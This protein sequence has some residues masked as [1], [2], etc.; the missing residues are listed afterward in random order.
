MAVAACITMPADPGDAEGA[1]GEAG[2][3]SSSSGDPADGALDTST[4]DVATPEG[5]A[6]DAPVSDGATSDGA[7]SDPD[8][9]AAEAGSS[10]SGSVDPDPVGPLGP[11]YGVWN[12]KY[13]LPPSGVCSIHG[14]CGRIVQGLK[15]AWIVS[16]TGSSPAPQDAWVAGATMATGGD[17]IVH[18]VDGQPRG[19]T[20]LPKTHIGPISGSGPNDVWIGKLH[21]DGA[22]ISVNPKPP[23]GTAPAFVS[24]TDAW[25]VGTSTWHWDGA[26]WTEYAAGT[27]KTL[28]AVIAFGPNDAWAV[29][30]TA[31]RHWNGVAWSDPP[32]PLPPGAVGDV[33]GGTSSSDLWVGG[34]AYVYRFNG[35][36]WTTFT[37]DGNVVAIGGTTTTTRV[38]TTT[39]LYA[40]KGATLAYDPSFS[41]SDIACTRCGKCNGASV[42]SAN[43]DAL[44]VTSFGAVPGSGL[45]DSPIGT[46]EP[47]RTIGFVTTGDE[48]SSGPEQFVE[49]PSQTFALRDGKPTWF[50]GLWGLTNVDKAV[51]LA[52]RAANDLWVAGQSESAGVASHWDG[53][54][55]MAYALPYAATSTV[56]AANPAM[57]WVLTKSGSSAPGAAHF[58]GAKWTGVPGPGS[59]HAL[60]IWGSSPTDAVAV[61]DDGCKRWNGATWSSTPC[62][63]GKARAVTGTGPADIWVYG[64]TGAVGHWNGVGWF[65]H[66]SGAPSSTFSAFSI[67]AWNDVWATDYSK[68]T[69]TNN[70]RHW[71]GSKWEY[72]TTGSGYDLAPKQVSVNAGWGRVT[73][74]AP[75]QPYTFMITRRP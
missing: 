6:T 32:V 27:P 22:S 1:L 51:S 20:G 62:N 39:R 43:A 63:V 58:D 75:W 61:G 21:W 67:E 70:L 33:I 55:F 5:G 48:A 16:W 30:S 15:Y 4:D 65:S 31:L 17:V 38:V 7:A 3:S 59:T 57:A 18:I 25:S 23:P 2:S 40:W 14:W 68:A 49:T 12:G 35:A 69:F 53:A 56:A 26:D 47:L 52:G 28:A 10:D 74:Q 24:A 54:A 64:A 45:C 41:T 36:A 73:G 29:G 13:E 37:V 72:T 8:A 46:R 11:S 50:P 44:I 42:S 9:G 60:A 19:L 71:N 66:A 34:G